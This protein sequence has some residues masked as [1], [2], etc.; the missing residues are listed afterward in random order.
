MS[1]EKRKREHLAPFKD[2]GVPARKATTWL[3]CV[4]LVHQ[5]L[6][7]LALDEV[8]IS[9]TFAGHPFRAPLF[10]TGMTGGTEEARAVNRTLARVAERMGIG[11]GLGSQRAMVEDPTLA[12]TYAVRDCAPNVFLAG[13]IGGVQLAR[14][15]LA[16]VQ[17]MVSR[18][19]ADALCVHLN[20]AQELVQAGGDRDFRG[21]ASAIK[22]AVAHLTVPIIVKEVGC[23]VSREAARRLI[24][25]GVRHLD[26]AGLGGT[27]W[28]G[29]ELLR[30]GRDSDP[31]LAAFWDWG[32]PT[33]ASVLEVA[34]LGL[35]V[36]AS[37]GIR[38][39][40]DA[41]RAIALGATLVGVAAPVLQAY[42]LGGEALVQ[43]RLE[44]IVMG[45]K[46][47]MLLTGSRDIWAFQ[48]APKV[49]LT[50]LLEWVRQR[51]GNE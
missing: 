24:D 51:G 25:L 19:Q 1:T 30:G 6:P 32:I 35:E 48:K 37:G 10:I 12:E 4:H 17:D 8:D 15:P 45:I 42:F 20:P 3:E 13:N 41:A 23:G 40:L 47:A 9:V 44:A 11:F 29:V 7:E 14:L 22:E 31:D 38:T 33:A 46:Q 43:A 2:T 36:I 18:V 16:T 49:L 27:S 26:T 50:P 39:G 28:V 5:P 34:G 21:V